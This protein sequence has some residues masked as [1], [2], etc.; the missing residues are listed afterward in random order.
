MPCWGRLVNNILGENQTSML[1][2]MVSIQHSR[3]KE[4]LLKRLL[5]SIYLST[6]PLH[7]LRRVWE[8]GGIKRAVPVAVLCSHLLEHPGGLGWVGSSCLCSVWSFEGWQVL[9]AC[10]LCGV[11]A[12]SPP[13]AQPCCIFVPAPLN[14]GVWLVEVTWLPGPLLFWRPKVP[15]YAKMLREAP[16]VALQVGNTLNFSSQVTHLIPLHGVVQPFCK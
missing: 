16:A 12:Q 4:Q 14:L 5:Y 13:A 11:S 3:R 10:F 6:S 7:I 2:H 9:R 15:S 8:R 1:K